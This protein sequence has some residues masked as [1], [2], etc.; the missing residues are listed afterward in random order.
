MGGGEGGGWMVV[1]GEKK[2]WGRRRRWGRV[3]GRVVVTGEPVRVVSTSTEK[4]D[5]YTLDKTK[6]TTVRRRDIR[7]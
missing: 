2:G 4:E 5:T 1:E 3:H 7:R 6:G